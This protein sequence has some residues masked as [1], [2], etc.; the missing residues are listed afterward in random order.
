MLKKSKK[1]ITSMLSSCL[2]MGIIPIS[3]I[4]VNAEGKSYKVDLNK[5]NPVVQDLNEIG[6]GFTLT[7][8]VELVGSDTADF[9]AV[10]F[11][12]NLLETNNVKVN[13]V[14]KEEDVNYN[15]TVI[16]L[17]EA[18]GESVDVVIENT[19]TALPDIN[20]EAAFSND[21]G[22][23]LYTSNDIQGKESGV[24][25]IA[26]KD[27]DGTYYGART[28]EQIIQL[29][30]T[31]I[32]V[33]EVDV[34]DYPEV[35]FR[36]IVEGFY[37][38]PWTHENRLGLLE[39]S[40]DNKMNTYIYGPKDDPYHRGKWREPYPQAEAQKIAE[41][42]TKATENKVDFVWAVH[43]G[44]DI[45]FNDEDY[46]TLLD[47]FEQM[48]DLG[49][50][51]FAVFFDD[52]GGNSPQAQAGNQA[53]L[54]NKLNEDFIKVKGDVAPLILCPTEYNK[55]WANKNPGTYLDILGDELDPSIQVMWTGNDVMSDMDYETLDWVNKRINREAYVWWNF[56]VNDYCRDKLLL[57]SSYGLNPNMSNAGGFTSNPMNQAEASKFALFSVANHTWNTDAYNS[58]QSWHNAIETLVPEVAED[59]K[60][61]STHNTDP[62][63]RYRRKESEHIA[64]T[65][66]SFKNKLSNN[67]SVVDDG[68]RLIQEF[69]A[70]KKAGSNII[71]NCSNKT[72]VNEA[73]QWLQSFEQ[74]GIAGE[75]TVKAVIALQEGEYDIWWNNY[76]EAKKALD[77]MARI[78]KHNREVLKKSGITVSSQKLTPFVKSM[79]KDVEGLYINEVYKDDDSVYKVKPYTS[80][81][82]K[83]SIDNMLDGDEESYWYSQ[84]LQEVGDYYG[85]DLGKVIPIK[86]IT[87][88]QGRND[89]D[90]DRFHKGIL[91]YSIDGETW[92]AIG[93]ERTETKISEENLNIEARYIRYRATY[94]GIPGGKPD[95]WTAIREFTV[96]KNSGDKIF[97]NIESINNLEV[98]VDSQ[99]GSIA[100]PQITDLEIAPKS[101]LGIELKKLANINEVNLAFTG[102]LSTLKLQY[103]INGIEWTD[104]ETTINNGELIATENFVAK[105]VR[106]LNNSEEVVIGNLSKFEAMRDIEVNKIASTNAKIYEGKVEN[107]TDGNF[108]TYLWTKEQKVGDYYEVDLGAPIE[109]HDVNIYSHN[110]DY[111]RS[112]LIE[113]SSDGENW[114]TIKDFSLTP[115]VQESRIDVTADTK[116]DFNVITAD[117]K[118]N[119]Y[120]YIRTR[121]TAPSNMWTKVFEITF[122]ETVKK[123][124]VSSI[125]STI[126]GEINKIADGRMDTAFQSERDIEAEDSIIYKL[127]DIKELK[128]IHILQDDE[129]ISN[130][131]VSVRTV[132]NKWLDVGVLDKAFNNINLQSLVDSGNSNKI[133]DIKISWDENA[134]SSKI[135]EINTLAGKLEKPP[136]E[137]S[138]GKVKLNIPD[139]IK[140]GEVLSIG[141]GLTEV[142][143]EVNAYAADYTIKYDPAVF[144]FKEANS[145]MDGIY[146]NSKEV[147]EGEIRVLVASLS[148]TELP[149]DLDFIN[150]LLESK[151]KAVDSLISASNVTIGND[152]GEIFEIHGAEKSIV[153]EEAVNPPVTGVKPNK[154]SD[155]IIS[156][157]TDSTISLNWQAP[158][159]IP[160]KEYIIYK[161]GIQLETI[162]G[163]ETTYKAKELKANTLYGFK[164]VAVSNDN[165]KSRPISVNGRTK[166]SSKST[167]VSMI[168]SLLG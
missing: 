23:T 145:S 106:V 154:P 131:K 137:E 7:D 147:V 32:G 9:Q 92:T 87:I 61:F 158:D 14:N 136:V 114:T 43:P 109:L 42:A 105:Y 85:V 69:Q 34:E 65:L 148:G 48:Y 2:I 40:G 45:N 103:S 57:G 102:E 159:N 30:G 101:Y 77:E 75:S 47:K 95:L 29:D 31:N 13:L 149:K 76:L 72:L 41:L 26:G 84:A 12:K 124:E 157:S 153:V 117:A 83:G 46:N 129:V 100:Y 166:K 35:S 71:K 6:E 167:L 60:V 36:G 162:P 98:I 5:I 50:R 115:Q 19:I 156:E 53:W 135:Y 138:N 56:P 59:F 90:H 51:G 94:A 52:I 151:T 139:K 24:I 10:K 15:N 80:L 111:I 78:D 126:P 123:D 142:K 144:D 99:T 8:T 134:K 168:R 91:E 27:E 121:M 127:T 79:F 125:E 54:L 122:N 58:E 116:A 49:V 163:T 97:T 118:G 73:E 93:E 119:K 68:E 146:V 1:F 160:V 17:G 161:D 110:S 141:L 11:L 81:K 128:N 96:N 37:G 113:V 152:E 107:L 21:E 22:Y 140:A 44:G 130:G 18:T 16:I 150:V 20:S 120:R 38:D 55:S 33:P 63:P 112:G 82:D 132:D 28:L 165:L 74:L 155:L 164:I 39:M 88:I 86:D 3:N 4:T 104:L 67:E 66:D 108:N 133:L 62:G 143:E 25:V 89:D 70:I 64:S